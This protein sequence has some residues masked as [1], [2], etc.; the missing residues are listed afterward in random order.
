[1]YFR[2]RSVGAMVTGASTTRVGG[3]AGDLAHL[4]RVR[5]ARRR[6]SRG[7]PRRS[8]CATGRAAPCRPAS[9][10][11]R[12]CACRR[13]RRSSPML[14]A[15]PVHVVR[16]DPGQPPS[17]SFGSASDDAELQRRLSLLRLPW[18]FFRTL[19]SHGTWWFMTIVFVLCCRAPRRGA[20]Y[21]QSFA[22]GGLLE[23]LIS[24]TPLRQEWVIRP[25]REARREQALPCGIFFSPA[26]AAMTRM[27][28]F[29][30]SCTSSSAMPGISAITD[31]VRLLEDVDHRLEDLGHHG[32]AGRSSLLDVAEWLDLDA[33]VAEPEVEYGTRRPPSSSPRVH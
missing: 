30:S 26:V 29:S 27:S 8:G 15:E 11:R 32:G 24:S 4:A 13:P 31:V 22:L 33:F 3:P 14:E 1:M 17:E 9:P 10:C 28:S 25:A 2:S 18:S 19:R 7:S 23:A 20:R 6:R 12:S 5:R 21:R 16:V